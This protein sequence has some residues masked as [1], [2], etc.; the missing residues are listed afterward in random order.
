MPSTVWRHQVAGRGELTGRHQL[1]RHHDVTQHA[2]YKGGDEGGPR[3]LF[4]V[5]LFERWH[6]AKAD[7]ERLRK[8]VKFAV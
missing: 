6:E 3:R 2:E 8:R 4:L 7:G 1:R 5:D